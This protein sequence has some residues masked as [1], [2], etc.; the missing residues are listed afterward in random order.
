MTQALEDYLIGQQDVAQLRFLT[1][2]SVDD[3]KS[4]LIGR[5]LYD[6]GHVLDDQHAALTAD[7]RRAGTTGAEPDLALLVD[8]L[9]AEREQ[10]I[11][12][13]VAY[14][15]FATDRRRFVVADTPG[16]EQYT[17]NMVT[18]ASTA[19]A[20]VIL[21]DATKGLLVQ[22]R[23]HSHVVRLLEIGEV[24]LAVNKLD[25]VGYSREVFEQISDDYTR[26]ARD[27]G[28]ASVT[29]VPVSALR[30]DNIAERSPHTPWYEGPTLLECL[31]TVPTD[32]GSAP[33]DFRLPVQHVSRPDAEFRGYAG[34]VVGGAIRPGDRVRA[35]P[36]GREARIARIV[37]WDGD[38]DEAVLGQSVTVTLT[39][40][41][42]VS[43]GDVLCSADRPA[44]VATHF[45]ARMIWMSEQPLVAGRRYLVKVGTCVVGGAVTEL[46]HAIDVNTLEQKPAVQ[47]GLNEIG[48][49]D[50]ALDRPVA[51]DPYE[52]NP[53]LGGVLL[54]DPETQ[55]TIGVALLG[56]A[57]TQANHLHWQRIDVDKRARAALSDQRPCVVWLT[58]VP[59]AGKSTI[60]NILERY[61]HGLGKHTYL[62]DG[63]NIRHGLNRDL[64][65]AEADRVENVRRIAEVARLMVDAG[66]IVLV[67]AISPFR[68]ERNMARR[69]VGED[70]FCEVFVDT[71]LAVAE[72]RDRK[73]LYRKARAGAIRDFTGIDSRYEPP[74]RPD[75]WIETSAH[76]PERA[77][78]LI[79][80][81]LRFMGVLS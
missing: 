68:A 14:R 37:T 73:G 54:I 80:E 28:L 17:R 32:G 63:D 62:L 78:E 7:S 46:R 60:A 77:V 9:Q 10:G 38:V 1:C 2:G 39:E 44:S 18:G 13:D 27:L 48:V 53:D 43:R 72:Q 25:A 12:I 42:D 64:G 4:T 3:G 35:L 65:F 45:E 69:M 16:H 36:S 67:S 41:I 34:M 58:G 47:L 81:R 70:E 8:G 71:P 61:L 22:T 20:A 24:I 5:L 31:E 75:V 56:S 66:L 11:T 79:V 19:D 30:G 74:E 50:L 52:E 40:G 51:Y 21:V 57:L 26:F 33:Q 23:R 15:Y 6:A 59:G 49:C 76:S 29:C 55:E